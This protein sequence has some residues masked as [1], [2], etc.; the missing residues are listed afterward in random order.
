[1][2]PILLSITVFLAA[3]GAACAGDAAWSVSAPE[4]PLTWTLRLDPE[5]RLS[6]SIAHGGA[7][8]V[9]SSALGLDT[10]AGGFASGLAFGLATSVETRTE[11]YTL[12]SGKRLAHAA[13]Y[14]V[15]RLYFQ[16]ADARVLGIEVRV[17]NDG[18][19]FRYF[20]PDPSEEEVT[21]KAEHTAFDLPTPGKAWMHPYDVIAPWAPAY[22]TFYADELAIG[23][24]A[25][26]D[27]N[28]WAF[29]MLFEV[30][31]RWVLISETGHAG[32]YP[33]M[34]IQP[35]APGGR[36]TLRPPEPE[37][38]EG[39]CS[40]RGTRALPWNLP[41]RIFIVGDSLATLVESD[42]ATHVAEPN[43]LEDT[44][45]IRPGRASWSWWSDG[46][47][48][49]D[50]V[51]LRAFVDFSAA[52]GWEYSLVDA[53]WD[54]MQGGDLEMLAA[55]ANARGVGLLA[56]YNSGGPRNTITEKPRNRMDDRAVRRAEF[57]KLREWGVKG[58]KVD[59][60]QSDKPCMLQQYIDIL[61]D[62]ADFGIVVNFHGCTLPRGWRRTYPNLLT[63]E[64]VRGGE[65]YR[66]DEDY[67]TYSPIHM[68]IATYTRNVIG[69]MD[70]TPVGLSDRQYPHLTTY[71]HELAQAVVYES[72]IQ[73]FCDH[74]AA[75]QAL[76]D[77]ALKLLREVPAVWDETRFLDGYP[78]DY[79]V[80]ARR[81]GDRWYVAGLNGLDRPLEL[82]VELSFLEQP[83]RLF[84]ITSDGG[85]EA[86]KGGSVPVGAGGSISLEMAPRDGFVGWLNLD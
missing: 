54:E 39:F 46:D 2:N 53:N 23:T 84:L 68:N 8:V 48:P 37:E 64:S 69:P 81:R 40:N 61:E 52:M 58:I 51:K 73:H 41:W 21:I 43:R 55:Y 27:K 10:S 82:E 9:E 32:D 76:P 13:A 75:Y 3:A 77:F 38:A 85:R 19:A 60:F 45:W 17:F 67:P 22:E 34:H 7:T 74:Y 72:G 20:F 59:F 28:G 25:P 63:L 24:T 42:L 18:V 78:G 26:A 14:R 86:L 11:T 66:F 15:Q 31:D 83:G 36:Y 50:Y 70:Y 71:A 33:G 65:A 49:K 5:G 6:Y 30:N 80:L 79:T 56:W 16:N 57:A 62:A 44:S 1:M 12:V 47:S 29:P 35:E 4:A